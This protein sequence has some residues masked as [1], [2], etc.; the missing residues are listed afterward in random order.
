MLVSWSRS[1]GQFRAGSRMPQKPRPRQ[2]G[3]YSWVEGS[4]GLT[5]DTSVC[6]CPLKPEEGFGDYSEPCHLSN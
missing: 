3:L 6:F 5:K 4:A 1:W 2:R